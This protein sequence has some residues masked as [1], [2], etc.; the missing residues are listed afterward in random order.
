MLNFIYFISIIIYLG[1]II[2]RSSILNFDRDQ[3][4]PIYG[5]DGIPR[6]KNGI[7]SETPLHI[8]PLPGDPEKPYVQGL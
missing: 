3:K 8:F 1:G 7:Y 4:I 2:L 5:F 6:F